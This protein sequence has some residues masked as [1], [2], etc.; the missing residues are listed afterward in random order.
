MR[1]VASVHLTDSAPRVI[2]IA[3]DTGRDADMRAEAVKTL[4]ALKP[5]GAVDVF[6]ETLFDAA[7]AVRAASITALR[8]VA[9]G[10]DPRAAGRLPGTRE[11]AG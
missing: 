8:E 7:S 3:R 4:C 2:A 5:A 6:K 1:L 9:L 10:V 11:D